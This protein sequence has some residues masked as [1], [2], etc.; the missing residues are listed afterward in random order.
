MIFDHV[1]SDTFD[2]RVILWFF[3]N[4][5]LFLYIATA[6]RCRRIFIMVMIMVMIMSFIVCMVSMVMMMV[7]LVVLMRVS[8]MVMVMTMVVIMVIVSMDVL[9]LMCYTMYFP[10]TG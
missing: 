10:D 7:V 5:F 9:T 4:Q 2:K 3:C 1:L 6:G 8:I